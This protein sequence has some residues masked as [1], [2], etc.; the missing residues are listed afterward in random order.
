MFNV[1]SRDELE[2]IDAVAGRMR[3]RPHRDPRESDVDPKTI[4]TFRRG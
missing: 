3:K 1:E 2:T 4:R